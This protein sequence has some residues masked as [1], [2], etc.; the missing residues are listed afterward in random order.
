VKG[1]VEAVDAS[2]PK[3]L[4]SIQTLRY[5]RLALAKLTP[6][7]CSRFNRVNAARTDHA[8]ILDCHTVDHRS[9]HP[10]QGTPDDARVCRPPQRIVAGSTVRDLSTLFDPF[11]EPAIIGKNVVANLNAL[12][13]D[14]NRGRTGDQLANVILSLLAE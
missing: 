11:V 10:T 14:E 6:C 5:E 13:A 9:R 2:I 1:L 8:T 7:G 4:R 12:V 3:T